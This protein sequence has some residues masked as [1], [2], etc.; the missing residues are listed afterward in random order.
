MESDKAVTLQRSTLDTVRRGSL[1]NENLRDVY[2]PAGTASRLLIIRNVYRRY[3]D[4]AGLVHLAGLFLG[5]SCH[6]LRFRVY[7]RISLR[8]SPRISRHPFLSFS[9]LCLRVGCVIARVG[10][11][12]FSGNRVRGF[13]R[14]NMDS[15]LPLTRSVADGPWF[16]RGSIEIENG[17]NDRRT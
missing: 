15:L 5:T 1:A 3:T 16:D 6:E 8:I 17:Y 11:Q 12:R 14:V 9:A 13:S 2:V 4:T 7:P 10:G